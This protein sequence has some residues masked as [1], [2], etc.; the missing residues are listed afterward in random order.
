MKECDD[1]IKRWNDCYSD[2][3]A[4]EAARPAIEEMTKA[5]KEQANDPYGKTV[6][7]RGCKMALD[8]FPTAACTRKREP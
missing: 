1:Y 7:P 6:L 8:N 2:P 4:R 3:V 5:W